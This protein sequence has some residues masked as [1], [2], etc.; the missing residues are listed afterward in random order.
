MRIRWLERDGERVLQ[1][2]QPVLRMPP[3]V[4]ELS[5]AAGPGGTVEL[6]ADE[7][8]MMHTLQAAE[9]WV[10]VPTMVAPKAAVRA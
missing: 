4:Q 7:A 1:V 6:T 8:R 5:K 2:L 3:R 10:D 9:E